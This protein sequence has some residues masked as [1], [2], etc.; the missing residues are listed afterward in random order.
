MADIICSNCNNSI[1]DN[2]KVCPV[3]KK[4]PKKGAAPEKEKIKIE[5]EAL[6]K[7][8]LVKNL[9]FLA[10]LKIKITGQKASSL[11]IEFFIKPETEC[12]DDVG[13]AGGFLNYDLKIEKKLAGQKITV[14]A[15]ID[16]LPEHVELEIEV[17]FLTWQAE[18]GNKIASWLL[19]WAITAIIGNLM[20]MILPNWF[21]AMLLVIFFLPSWK[22]DKGI[23]LLIDTVIFLTAL[24]TPQTLPLII[25]FLLWGTLVIGGIAY[26]IE[27]IWSAQV[28]G[29]KRR[30]WIYPWAPFIVGILA[31]A[32]CLKIGNVQFF[33]AWLIFSIFIAVYGSID[34]LVAKLK[35]IREEQKAEAA[36]KEKAGEKTEAKDSAEKKAPQDKFSLG[37]LIA[38]AAI[39]TE[40]IESINSFVRFIGRAADKK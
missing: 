27:E 21:I 23:A 28:F 7:T 30:S 34:D 17:P 18:K 13:V 36:K 1:P 35:E 31:A 11:K 26:S 37:W 5:I 9:Y 14:I 8:I 33:V 29:S 24:Y 32:I 40:S 19:G 38:M 2:V 6:G 16:G 3:C 20:I 10:P 22:H 15:R 4:N 25:I 12:Y 39:A